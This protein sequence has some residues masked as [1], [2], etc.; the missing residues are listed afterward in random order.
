[1]GVD[2]FKMFFEALRQR[3]AGLVT[4]LCFLA[5]AATGLLM[6][7]LSWRRWP[8]LFVDFGREL[9]IPW[10]IS[11]GAVL[12]KD[13]AY[14]HGPLSPYLNALLFK[15]FGTGLLT[16]ALFNIFLIAILAIIIYRIFCFTADRL[17]A[18]SAAVSFLALFAFSQYVETGNYNFVCPYAHGLTH[19]VF[20]AF[21]QFYFLM[22]YLKSRKKRLLALCGLLTGLIFL[23][24]AE[25]FFAAAAALLAAAF[26]VVYLDRPN[27]LGA[28]KMF[29]LILAGFL[30]PPVFYLAV[31]AAS[32]LPLDNSLAAL[33]FQYTVIFSSSAASGVF[34]RRI[35]GLDYPLRNILALLKAAA[36]YCSVVFSFWLIEYGAKRVLRNNRAAGA[37]V[38]SC[39]LALFIKLC[40]LAVK[41]NI[42]IFRP[43]PLVALAMGA[44]LFLL[45]ARSSGRRPGEAARPLLLFSMAV[46]SFLLL[47]KIFLNARIYH[48]GFVLAMPAV[49]LSVALLVYY[50]PLFLSRFFGGVSLA[51]ALGLVLLAVVLAACVN[52]SSSIYSFKTYAIGSGGDMIYDFGPEALMRSVYVRQAIE[53]IEK[54]IGKNETFV[55]F[56]EGVMLNYLTRRK[57]PSMHVNFMLPEIDVFGELWILGELVK[58]SP[59]YI[60]L[61]DRGMLEY[62]CRFPGVDCLRQIMRWIKDSYSP[63]AEIGNRPF[64]GAGFGIIIS[65]RVARPI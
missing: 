36:W 53:Q 49:L 51:R 20:L 39:G 63:V 27:L 24:K 43:L 4:L 2:R 17:A 9:Y 54:T 47:L 60:V 31:S 55:V 19:G 35:M 16:L 13:L 65:K 37:V 57:N 34:Y 11:Q 52:I 26:W 38:V 28:L 50:L 45:L 64:S 30:I 21:C 42:R 18:V 56:P 14:F 3:R 33:F 1:M 58:G 46:F 59:D 8:D 29:G 15:L 22:Q 7:R 32:G 44:Y 61:V 10:Q 62:G 5:P 48:F 12:Y 6:L 23:T 41:Y 40:L 25:V